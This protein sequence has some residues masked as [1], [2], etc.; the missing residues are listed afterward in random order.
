MIGRSFVTRYAEPARKDYTTTFIYIALF[1]VVIAASALLFLPHRWYVW[2][3]IIVVGIYLLVSY[4]ARNTGYRCANCGNA[5]EISVA[6]DLVSPHGIGGTGGWKYLKCPECGRRS[7]A[8]VLKKLAEE[9]DDREGGA[10]ET[11]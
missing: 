5:F 6:T 8:A 10:G 3:A 2:G 11:R 4:D 9:Q 7:R 1:A